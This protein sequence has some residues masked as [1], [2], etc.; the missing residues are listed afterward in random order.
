MLPRRKWK[1]LLGE[2]LE[3]RRSLEAGQESLSPAERAL[4]A[5]RAEERLV[6]G[7]SSR[8]R[9]SRI[10]AASALARY[11]AEGSRDALRAAFKKERDGVARLYLAFA[12]SARADPE[13]AADLAASIRGS[14]SAYGS[15]V[16]ALICESPEPLRDLLPDLMRDEDPAVASLVLRYASRHPS[17]A[18]REYAARTARSRPELA[19]EAAR[20]LAAA[21]PE[22]LD[23]DFFLRGSDPELARVAFEALSRVP[24]RENYRRLLGIAK[25]AA[26]SGRRAA[27]AASALAELTRRSPGLLAGIGEEFAAAATEAERG[28]FA[29]I[30]SS[31]VEYYI[32]KLLSADRGE[33]RRVLEAVLRSGRYSDAIAFLNRNRSAE[34][35]NELLSLFRKV[36]RDRPGL[37]EDCALYLNPRSLAKLGL[38]PR[39]HAAPAREEKQERG[40]SSALALLLGLIGTAFL[41]SI[42]PFA[43][44]GRLEAYV[45]GWNRFF[46][47]YSIAVNSIALLLLAVS[48]AGAR[49]ASALRSCKGDE[50]LFK[51]GMLPSVTI[52]APAY[53]EEATIV[54]SVTALLNLRYP[55]YEVVVVNDGSPDQTL[56]ALIER[57]KLEKTDAVPEGGLGTKPLRG[58]YRSPSFPILTVVDKS[59]GGKADALNAGI[60]VSR[61]EYVCGIDADRLLEG[62]AL[63]AAASGALDTEDEFVASGGAILPV[64]GCEVDRGVV[65]RIGVPRDPV[66]GFQ[67]IEYIRS[68][69][70]GRVGW[71]RL[72]CLLIVSGAFGLFKKDRVV[73]A[74]GYLAS[75]GRYQTDTVGEDMELIVRLRRLMLE[76]GAPHS[77]AYAHDAICWTEVPGTL[78]M[79]RRQRDRWHRGLIEVLYFHRK[80]ILNP[81]Y[82]RIG[83]LAMPYFLLFEIIG[84]FVEALGYLM[85]AAAAVLGLLN[86]PFL[87]FLLSATILYGILVSLCSLMVPGREGRFRGGKAR[88]ALLGYA[89][90]ENLGFRQLANLWRVGGF[91]SSMRKPKGWGDMARAGFRKKRRERS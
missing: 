59:N 40:K 10:R 43:A 15:R 31:R 52:V 8:F 45:L 29:D 44:S 48:F 64:N 51:E 49:L 17:A 62:E 60:N 47:C 16:A 85:V 5:E 2:Y 32:A 89:V 18:L 57:F 23:D 77:V 87:L 55:D 27:Y 78:R 67:A 11:G 12:L 20:A 37:E 34:L 7:L 79:L 41:A 30:L 33:A 4:E 86:G 81:R 28:L 82:G 1:R 83:V 66:A 13:A 58:V 6:R 63:L 38:E 53:R 35:E 61:K 42:V 84:P 88:A 76:R 90:L 74:G 80:M 14:R 22:E 75:S 70:G 54:E 68:F 26:G 25:E 72:G 71:A 69:M 3:L 39:A 50:M 46:A 56:N 9:L 21:Y 73:E 19:L 65:E 36:M 91:F 24:S